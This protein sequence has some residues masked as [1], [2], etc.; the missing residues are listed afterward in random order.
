MTAT[1]DSKITTNSGVLY[2]AFELGEREWKLAF[3]IGM[4]QKA[5]ITEIE[6]WASLTFVGE[7]GR[8]AP[9]RGDRLLF[10]LLV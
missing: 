5:L 1:Y 6:S 2:L 7:R 4:G 9:A 8:E 3:T 10:P